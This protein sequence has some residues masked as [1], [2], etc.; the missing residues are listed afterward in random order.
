LGVLSRTIDGDIEEIREKI[1]GEG[2]AQGGRGL[3]GRKHHRLQGGIRPK[4][5]G[6]FREQGTGTMIGLEWEGEKRMSGKG[7]QIKKGWTK[8][9]V[10]ETGERDMATHKKHPGKRWQK[11]D[12]NSLFG[13]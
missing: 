2:S 6:T 1:Y 3:P 7:S 8:V 13:L 9:P 4:R 11:K 10:R 5:G 12:R